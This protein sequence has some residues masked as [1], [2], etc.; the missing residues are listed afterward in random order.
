MGLFDRVRKAFGGGAEAQ[1]EAQRLAADAMRQSGYTDGTIPTMADIQG[2]LGA[3]MMADQSAVQAYGDELR[4]ITAVGTRGTSVITSSVDTGEQT[5][6]NH[7]YQLEV[8]VTL[9]G[10][11]P[12]TVSKRELVPTIALAQYAE[13]TAHDVAVDPADPQKIAFTS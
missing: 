6:G 11:K 13:G 7:W 4:R 3:Q 9:P 12:Y 5:V 8:Q 2:P 10:Q 1:A